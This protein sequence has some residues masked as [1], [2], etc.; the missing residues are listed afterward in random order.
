MGA[1]LETLFGAPNPLVV[2]VHLLPLPGSPFHDEG[3]GLKAVLDRAVADAEAAREGG[4][5]GIVVENFGD[6]PFLP[7]PVEPITTACVTRAVGDVREAVDLPCGVSVLRNDAAAALSIASVAGGSF[8]RVGV[9]TGTMVTDQGII[10]GTAHETLRLRKLLE[11]DVRIFGDFQVKHAAALAPPDLDRDARDLVERGLADT[12]VVSGIG[13]GIPA[14]LEIVRRVK[15]AIPETPVLLGSGVDAENVA[16]MLAAG[17]GAIVGSSV[18]EDG[19]LGQ[20]VSA[21]RVREL[22]RRGGRGGGGG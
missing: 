17:D 18:K 9:H 10:R 5:H 14:E 22:V 19:K 20:P 21:R 6:M 7:V 8:I 16:D 4:A 15:R 2:M 13:T 11:S 1:L 3:G 12:V